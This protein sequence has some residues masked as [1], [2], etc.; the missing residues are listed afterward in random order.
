MYE[1]LNMNLDINLESAFEE[2]A[3][4]IFEGVRLRY[5]RM[6]NCQS[7]KDGKMEFSDGL[8]T[9]WSAHNNTG[10]SVF[11]KILKAVS[12]PTSVSRDER[13]ELIRTKCEY[14]EV[15]YGF[16]DGS[17]SIVRIYP[18]RILYR[19]T[20]NLNSGSWIQSEDV[21]PLRLVNNLNLIV[22]LE[23][24][25]VANL[26]DSEQDLL[27]VNSNPNLNYNLVRVLTEHDKLNKLSNNFRNK[28]PMYTK[29]L[30]TVS[31]KA[32][33][34][35]HNRKGLEYVD[36]DRLI[37]ETE[38]EEA[39]VSS[40]LNI[41]DVYEN[42]L[43][44]EKDISV[45]ELP[46][47][48]DLYV[49]GNLL[50]ELDLEHFEVPQEIL[51]SEE[52]SADLATCE[53]L[54]DYENIL[55]SLQPLVNLEE[56]IRILENLENINSSIWLDFGGLLE[57]ITVDDELIDE[58]KDWNKLLINVNEIDTLGDIVQG[59]SH[60]YNLIADNNDLEKQIAELENID[61]EGELFDCP[62]HGKIQYLDG[63]CITK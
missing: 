29:E 38:R 9:I 52:L 62:L 17:A 35:R 27:L 31:T 60:L 48:D 6:I 44:L 14:A 39:L 12:C 22:D 61:F 15:H 50:N 43:D 21:P 11:M 33:R 36:V 53:Q 1:D 51:S 41:M 30:Q 19:F 59:V 46:N 10:K 49:F 42:T 3:E 58:D 13:K 45:N 26:L 7:W 2:I 37:N 20:E 57:A 23:N 34:L 18:Q 25:F 8:N 5:V 4:E 63:K 32:D 40:M 47:L 28:V 16:S 54:I 24:N 56:E 55:E